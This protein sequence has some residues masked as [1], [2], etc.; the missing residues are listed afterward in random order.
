MGQ[1]VSQPRHPGDY[2]GEEISLGGTSYMDTAQ[3]LTKVKLYKIP[4]ELL[5]FL[6]AKGCNIGSVMLQVL[7]YPLTAAEKYNT[8]S[9]A[10]SDDQREMKT[11]AFAWGLS[12]SLPFVV[13]CILMNGSLAQDTRKF[14]AILSA[15]FCMWAFRFLPDFILGMFIIL[16]SMALAIAPLDVA[17]KGFASESFLLL[18][19]ITVIGVNFIQSG[20][21]YR[22]I[23]TILHWV[24]RTYAWLNITVFAVGAMLTLIVPSIVRRCQIMA[25]FMRELLHMIGSRR[26]D[27]LSTAIAASAIFGTSLFANIILTGSLIN[28]VVW[29]M[30][31]T[32]EHEL[33]QWITWL[34]AAA[35]YGIIVGGLYSVL[36]LLFFAAREKIE[37]K[38]EYLQAQHQVLGRLTYKE[39]GTIIAMGVLAV[40]IV[41]NSWHHINFVWIALTIVVGLFIFDLF[42]RMDF[43]T[44]IDWE[45]LFFIAT[46]SGMVA[47]T[48]YLGLDTWF[49]Q[50]IAGLCE[51]LLKDNFS[52]LSI[53]T[54][55]TLAIR[56]IL[57][58]PAAVAI[59]AMIFFPLAKAF[60]HNLWL[61]G[62]IILV[63]VDIW[64][65]PNQCMFYLAFEEAA[66]DHKG[67]LYNRR[68]L[69]FFTL[70]VN[71][72]KI[73]AL[74]LSLPYWRELGLA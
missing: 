15:A 59:L 56:F 53:I 37:L 16:G 33:F 42:T 25:L 21:I 17:L 22:T 45:F 57:P 31:P 20:L 43:Q 19:C 26:Q 35:A 29:G 64:F 7:K 28:F 2:R 13:W 12:L 58:Q 1:D 3:A 34:K 4:A 40:G 65:V 72:I 8:N 62:F 44:N 54:A 6:T 52:F 68:Q 24:P 47:V 73:M 66:H 48:Q 30:L 70:G 23:L 69:T 61:A 38:E 10:R 71:I 14:L 9:I 39:W 11:Q 50:L 60:G 63:L 32:Q 49:T 41:T 36:A 27:L 51:S 74:Y 55:I 67:Y 5:S 18:V 46:V